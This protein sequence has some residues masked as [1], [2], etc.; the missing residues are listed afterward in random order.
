[1]PASITQAKQWLYA[2]REQHQR[3]PSSSTQLQVLIDSHAYYCACRE[4]SERRIMAILLNSS[5]YR[6]EQNDSPD[7]K[8]DSLKLLLQ[9]PD[10]SQPKGR[11]AIKLIVLFE[12]GNLPLI[13]S[14]WRSG[15]PWLKNG[16]A[17]PLNPA[18]PPC[19]QQNRKPRGRIG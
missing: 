1:M 16:E 14:A 3:D 19:K 2:L 4:V 7:A 8:P 13:I 15:S 5:T 9:D 10:E 12:P 18:S 6:W 17:C 11:R